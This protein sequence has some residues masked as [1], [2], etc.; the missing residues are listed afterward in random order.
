M[1]SSNLQALMGTDKWAGIVGHLNAGALEENTTSFAQIHIASS[2]IFEA[3]FPGSSF[4]DGKHYFVAMTQDISFNL[5]N[6][7]SVDEDD[8][9]EFGIFNQTNF[10]IFHPG[11]YSKADNPNATFCCNK[12]KI[13]VAGENFTAFSITLSNNIKYFLLKYKI[14]NGYIPAFF[15]ELGDYLCYNATSCNFE[16]L[17]P[18]GKTYHFYLLSKEPAYKFYIYIDGVETNT[19]QQTAL[20]YNLTIRVTYLYTGEALANRTIVVFENDG[21][22]IFIPRRLSGTI[23]RGMSLSKSDENGIVTFI[24]SPTEYPLIDTYSINIGALSNDII[25]NIKP[26]VVTNALSIERQKKHINQSSLSDNAKVAVNAMNQISNSLYIWANKEKMAKVYTI[27]CYMDGSYT[28]YNASDGMYYTSAE[29]QTGAPNVITYI[30]KYNNGTEAFGYAKIEETD[31]Y[32]V[33]T[34][35]YNPPIIGSKTHRHELIN[36]T[37]NTQFI[38]TPTSYGGVTSQVKLYLYDSLNN[39]KCQVNFNI[40]PNLE[41]RTGGVYYENDAMKTLINAMNSVLDSLYYALN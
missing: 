15:V 40:N 26:L 16:F 20:P 35:V 4:K 34:P 31:G 33:M 6:L 22:D 3:N 36:L 18:V 2:A 37:T 32:L 28:I 7:Y 30:L 13:L 1:Y 5:S 12:E 19:F 11:Y 29:L 25:T 17:L 38:I 27:T 39:L 10:P 9:K 21:N 8:L 23:A 24:V 41:P 14:N